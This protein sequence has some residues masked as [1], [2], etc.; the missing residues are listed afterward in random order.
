MPRSFARAL[1]IIATMVTVACGRTGTDAGALAVTWQIVPATPVA[2][3]ESAADVTLRLAS[4]AP[5]LGARVNLEGYMSHPGMAPLVA[6]LTEAGG[7][8]Y[9]A[10]L[11]L[12]MAGD[13]VMFV[14][15]RL[16][17]GRLVR[18]RVADVV[19]ATAE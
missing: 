13:W 18:Q 19:V 6:G 15:G 9:R 12:T 4:G 1:L 11:T 10:R 2:G 14:D 16:A 3:R 17:D 8:T 5:V 7:G